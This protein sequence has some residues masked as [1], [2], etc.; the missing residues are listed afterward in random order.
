[1][2]L[3]KNIVQKSHATVPLIRVYI[4]YC[5]RGANNCCIQNAVQNRGG[6]VVGTGREYSCAHERC[7]QLLHSVVRHSVVRQGV[8]M[9]PILLPPFF[10]S[11][12][13][14]SPLLSSY[15]LTYSFLSSSLLSS[16]L[17]TSSLPHTVRKKRKN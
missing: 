5:M 15:L 13:L 10:L 7:K 4:L 1:M 12:L 11:L 14:F 9:Y 17:L 2:I 8:S 3:E 6:C 16:P